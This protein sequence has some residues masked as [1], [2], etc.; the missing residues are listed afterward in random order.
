MTWAGYAVG[1]ITM[2][3]GVIVLALPL[4]IIGS[5]FHEERLKM[6]QEKLDSE[7]WS[8]QEPTRGGFDAVD[9]VTDQTERYMK[10]FKL[11]LYHTSE[12]LVTCTDMARSKHHQLPADVIIGPISQQKHMENINSARASRRRSSEQPEDPPHGS[13]SS[14]PR[15]DLERDVNPICE[16]QEAGDGYVRVPEDIIDELDDKVFAMLTRFNQIRSDLA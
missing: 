11:L 1:I 3:V 6:H 15:D 14:E 5:N 8:E 13:Q 16:D 9:N 4:S 12:V 7:H 2:L 10:D